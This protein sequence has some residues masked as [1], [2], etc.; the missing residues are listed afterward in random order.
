MGR[1]GIEQ[2]LLTQ[3]VE[4]PRGEEEH[5]SPRGRR[6]AS[7]VRRTA[8]ASLRLSSLAARAS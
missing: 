2:N 8:R 5:R 6:S 4:E 1:L 3:I 7:F